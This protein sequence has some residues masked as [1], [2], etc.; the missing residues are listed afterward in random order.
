V[1][2]GWT[3]EID[4]WARVWDKN[5]A[6][7]PPRRMVTKFKQ[8]FYWFPNGRAIPL[9][10]LFSRSLA[11]EYFLEFQR[12]SV[13]KRVVADVS[14]RYSAMSGRSFTFI[15][16]QAQSYGFRPRALFIMRDP[17]SRVISGIMHSNRALKNPREEQLVDLVYRN[18]R[19]YPVSARTRYDLTIRNLEQA[20]QLD[21]IL[22]L[23]F[24]DLFHEDTMSTL[25]S[26][27]DISPIE[28]DFEN[29]VKPAT[30]RVDLPA[31]LVEQI[32][33]HY[34]PVYDFCQKKF[35]AEVI[36]RLWKHT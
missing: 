16:N 27:L 14:P 23:F 17:V 9:S 12:I 33:R 34:N 10:P 20:F 4:L 29:V 8:G 32:R 26:W 5:L 1:G 11:R 18:Y 24:E 3:K 19:S 36:E 31:E 2:R 25:A 35:G 21:Q 15:H 28:G 7:R 13:G 6:D 30:F 22:Y